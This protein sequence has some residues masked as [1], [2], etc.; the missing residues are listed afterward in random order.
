RAALIAIKTSRRRMPVL[1]LEFQPKNHFH[2]ELACPDAARQAL[3]AGYFPKRLRIEEVHHRV[4]GG[5]EV[6]LEGIVHIQAHRSLKTF[7]DWE[8]LGCRSFV[9]QD[10]GSIN[11]V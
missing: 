5:K 2:K 8:F 10:P 4:R 9:P 11:N 7:A 3:G 6:A 1:S